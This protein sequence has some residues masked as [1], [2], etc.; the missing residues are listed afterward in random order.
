MINF[1]PLALC[2]RDRRC[3]RHKTQQPSYCPLSFRPSKEGTHQDPTWQSWSWSSRC[4]CCCQ[5][6]RRRQQ[7]E[8]GRV[9]WTAKWIEVTHTAMLLKKIDTEIVN[10][11]HRGRKIEKNNILFIAFSVGIVVFVN[12][13]HTV[14]VCQSCNCRWSNICIP[15]IYFLSPIFYS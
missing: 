4:S 12:Q 8:G 14:E 9:V 6:E 1:S 13:G 5:I 11:R 15:T 3:L 10:Q 7:Q 2:W